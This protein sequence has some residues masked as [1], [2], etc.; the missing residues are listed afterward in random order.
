MLD[1]LIDGWFDISDPDGEW[2]GTGDVWY[3]YQKYMGMYGYAI[4]D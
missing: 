1:G 3:W 2:D 4:E